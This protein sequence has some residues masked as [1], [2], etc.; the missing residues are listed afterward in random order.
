MADTIRCAVANSTRF[1]R[2]NI[3][4]TMMLNEKSVAPAPSWLIYNK[5]TNQP[6]NFTIT[7]SSSEM[8]DIL[9]QE[10]INGN[11][12]TFMETTFYGHPVPN[13]S[14]MFRLGDDSGIIL[15]ENHQKDIDN[16]LALAL[17]TFRLDH[18][19]NK[20]CVPFYNRFTPYKARI[21]YESEYFERHGRFDLLLPPLFCT[22]YYCTISQNL[23]KLGSMSTTT[24]AV[25]AILSL[26]NGQFL[27]NLNFHS[28][29]KIHNDIPLKEHDAKEKATR[30]TIIQEPIEEYDSD[31]WYDS[32]N[33]PSFE[34]LENIWQ[35]S[36]EMMRK[37]LEQ[38]RL[39][40]K[41][42]SDSMN[43]EDTT[44]ST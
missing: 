31:D 10:S 35:K 27:L 24:F 18:E 36:H 4:T 14:F 38:T 30:K 42:S 44:I 3:D 11:L 33:S 23:L 15:D 1:Y 6:S 29:I 21:H 39:R 43:Y 16:I 34:D 37:T 28:I 41:K 26:W 25:N 12:K 19:L 9:Y 2:Y 17:H 22:H 5:Q 40:Y 32:E 13:D 20:D 8:E 7:L